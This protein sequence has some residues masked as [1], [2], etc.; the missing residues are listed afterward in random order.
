MHLDIWVVIAAGGYTRDSG[1]RVVGTLDDV[2]SKW[3]P[4]R[5]HNHLPAV[6]THS[7]S[8]GV[9]RNRDPV[10][11]RMDFATIGEHGRDAKS[12]GVRKQKRDEGSHNEEKEFCGCVHGFRYVQ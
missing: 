6:R 2:Q 8:E 11:G 4:N 7:E 1:L 10:T 9:G 5:R 3:K 12:L